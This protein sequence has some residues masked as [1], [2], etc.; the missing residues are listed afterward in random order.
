MDNLEDLS[1][2]EED[3]A[4]RREG[5]LRV[6]IVDDEATA[7]G[8]LCHHLRDV[9]DCV[10]AETAS[11][12][13]ATFEAALQAGEFFHL[14]C[15]DI[16]LPDHIGHEAVEAIRGIE[17]SYGIEP[18]NL[19]KAIVVTA[20]DSPKHV[21]RSANYQCDGVLVKPVQKPDLMLLLKVIGLI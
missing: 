19:V 7:R 9:A 20:D 21:A 6:L 2:L 15:V 12:A 13:V 11:A 4:E 17:R 1:G 18:A 14:L 16:H 8:T 10:E 3:G 5:P